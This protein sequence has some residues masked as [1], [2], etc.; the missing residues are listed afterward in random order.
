MKI[1]EDVILVLTAACQAGSTCFTSTVVKTARRVCLMTWLMAA[2]LALLLGAMGLMIA[3][4]W[5]GLTP[6]LGSHWS[7]MIAAGASLVGSGI[8]L[9][10]SLAVSKGH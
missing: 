6:Y 10:I 7:A 4:L 9:A 3:A 5:I 2:A 1:L 8:F